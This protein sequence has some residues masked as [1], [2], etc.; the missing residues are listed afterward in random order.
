LS[1]TDNAFNSPQT[2][3]LNGTGTAVELNPPTLGFGNVQV[4]TS[5]TK[6]TTLTNKGSTKL[7]IKSI[8]KMGA[9]SDEFYESSNCGSSVAAGAS[10]TITVT[11]TPSERGSDSAD[12]DIRDSDVTSP[13]VVAL[14][15]AG[16]VWEIINRR[17]KCVT[18]ASAAVQATLAKSRSAAVPSVTGANRV[19]TRIIDLVD[20]NRIDPFATNGLN[21]ELLVRLWYPASANQN[22]KLADYTSPRVWNF[23]AELT[24]LPLPS[25]TANSCLDAPIADGEHPVVVFTHGYTG[26]FTDYT[27]LLE[28]LASRGY[29][30]VSIDHTYEATA[31]EFPDRRFVKSVVGSH[32]DNTWRTDD[33]TLAS[34]LSVRL[35]DVKFVIDELER[36]NMS[37]G[38]AFTGRL[39]LTRL[40]LTGHSLG[41]LTAWFGVQRDS[42]FRAAILLDPYL[43]DMPL[44][45]TETPVMLLTMGREQRN[46]DECQL[47]SDLL[48]PR[49]AVNL[50]GAEHVTPS[51][52]VWLAKG[53]VKTGPMGPEKT[54]A[55]VRD[56]IAAFLDTNVRGRPLDPLLTGPSSTFPD[57]E[58]TTQK[59]S[60]CGET[61]AH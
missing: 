6:T 20:P 13:Q 31:V 57:A 34:A 8:S 56:Y 35:D 39:D 14:S 11:F 21:R 38:N 12:I 60:L 26:T 52:L 25:V 15:G 41:G 5:S 55:A 47:W 19:G 54:I 59:Q 44:G 50:R 1:I 42:R 46:E 61:A 53:A 10:C 48:G 33:Q 23:F 9:D 28:D 58:V 22:C 27:F 37:S 43:P 24:G 45:S 36:L 17:R 32:L 49:L 4:G 2:V 3:S 40:A 7:T 29:V 30:V 51:D 18:T 16:C